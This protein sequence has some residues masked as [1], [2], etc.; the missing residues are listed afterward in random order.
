[1]VN[2]SDAI[3]QF[4]FFFIIR[5]IPLDE[6]GEENIEFYYLSDAIG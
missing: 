3:G 4:N 6:K 5:R 2:R 1:M